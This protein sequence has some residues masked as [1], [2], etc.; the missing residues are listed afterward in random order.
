MSQLPVEYVL[1]LMTELI[2]RFVYTKQGIPQL[3]FWVH[4]V[5]IYHTAYLTTIPALASFLSSLYMTVDSRLSNMPKLLKLSGRLE[6]L[7]S[8][9]GARAGIN[10]KDTIEYNVDSDDEDMDEEGDQEADQDQ[11]VD[12]EEG[13]EEEGE[14]DQ[15]EDVEDMQE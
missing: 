14:N 6:L 5:L 12:Q 1:P 13:A 7:L 11:E 4:Q 2:D 10:T 8:Q 3:I 15:G 9:P